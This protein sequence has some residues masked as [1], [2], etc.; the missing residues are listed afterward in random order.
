MRL[1]AAGAYPGR[2]GKCP[3]C[4]A[5]IRVPDAPTPIEVDVEIQDDRAEPRPSAARSSTFVAAP[6]GARPASARQDAASRGEWNG[7]IPVP[8]QSETRLRES[9]LYP[10]WGIT[11]L[12]LLV[13]LPPALWIT[14][15]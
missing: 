13:F 11:G 12:A 2:L 4:G 10:F 1:A 6:R 9:L 8:P 7:L 3:A 14:S 5:W 15:L